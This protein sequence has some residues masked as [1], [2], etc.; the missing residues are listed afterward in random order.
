MELAYIV[1]V[2]GAGKSS[3]VTAVVEEVLGKGV[4]RREPFKHTEYRGGDVVVL[5]EF[6]ES[7]S[8]TDSLSMSVAPK[9]LLWLESTR[10]KLV[11]GEGDRLGGAS[12]L[13]KV[14]DMGVKVRVVMVEVSV[15]VQQA[16][17]QERG[18]TY[19]SVWLKARLTKCLKTV[20]AF[21]GIKID[22]AQ[23]REGVAMDVRSFL[24]PALVE[25]KKT[26][27]NHP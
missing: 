19:S 20:S 23:T 16:R 18:S 9:V 15:E 17:L 27:L 3:A 24:F 14:A 6:R 12:W 21:D 10:A 13:G 5:G 4:L 11:I 25:K 26:K 1:G 22:G 2:P 8:G 7:F